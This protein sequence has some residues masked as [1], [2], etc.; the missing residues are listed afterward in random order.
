MVS[1]DRERSERDGARAPGSRSAGRTATGR[2]ALTGIAAAAAVASLS[3]LAGASHVDGLQLAARYTARLS[4]TLF[5]APYLASPLLRLVP[6]AGTRWM[7]RERR[8]LGLA[9]AG[10]HAVHLAAFVGFLVAAGQRPELPTVVVGGLGYVLVAV[11]A[12][13]SNDA[14]VRALGPARWRRLHAVCLH[15]I[16]FVFAITYALRVAARHEG[17][18]AG[19]TPVALHALF[20]MIAFVALAV[21][22]AARRRGLSNEGIAPLAPSGKA[23]RGPTP[24]GLASLAFWVGLLA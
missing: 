4:F 15:Y 2:L 17:E 19:A 5:L 11:M 21:R 9:F 6:A 10:A 16:W 13:T 23:R 1:I 3:F 7:V 24:R 8:G 20:L 14:A 22:L 12:A 18:S